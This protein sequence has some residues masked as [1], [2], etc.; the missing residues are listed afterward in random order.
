EPDDDASTDQILGL[1]LGQ[2]LTLRDPANLAQ[3]SEEAQ[4]MYDLLIS[5]ELI[6]EIEAP[7][8]PAYATVVIADTEEVV[9][10]EE[11]AQRNAVLTSTL[12]GLAQTGEGNV[13]AASGAGDD[14]VTAIRAQEALA[15]SLSTVDGVDLI[16]GQVTVP[17]ALAADIAG[18]TGAYG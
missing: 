11:A 7:D 14:L 12:T 3:P 6:G 5:S 10:A 1:A 13:V 15:S 17:L 8:E 2:A 18:E 4:A 16:T 9:D